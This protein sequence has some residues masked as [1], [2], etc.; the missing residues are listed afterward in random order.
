MGGKTIRGAG[1]TLLT[2]TIFPVSECGV[3]KPDL[4]HR[5]GRWLYVNNKT[6]IVHKYFIKNNKKKGKI[7]TTPKKL[8][9]S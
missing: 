6:H 2:K 1:G 9:Y 4:S 7:R 8:N 3:E 5:H